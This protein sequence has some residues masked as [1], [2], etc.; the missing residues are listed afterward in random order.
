LPLLYDLSDK[1]SKYESKE[2]SLTLE[3][4]YLKYWNNVVINAPYVSK[5]ISHELVSLFNK[6]SN[7]INNPDKYPKSKYAKKVLSVKKGFISKMD[8]YKIGMA[9]L[10]LGAGR[11][12]KSDIIDHKAGIIFRKKFGDFIE[13]GELICELCSDSKTKIKI[14]E[15][16]MLGAI[17]FSKIKS[18]KPK[19]VKKIISY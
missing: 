11:K 3:V 17:Q 8:T 16:M 13:R 2:H 6:A 19:L 9:S 15:E 12:T 7:Y 10:E 5:N 1:K 14:A 4:P 18:S